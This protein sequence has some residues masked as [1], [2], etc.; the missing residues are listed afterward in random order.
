MNFILFYASATHSTV[1]CLG[2]VSLLYRSLVHYVEELCDNIP[3]E[4]VRDV[5]VH[6][7]CM[8]VEP[9]P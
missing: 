6:T 3:D 5:F 4:T 8:P 1:Q 2:N 9:K 7:A